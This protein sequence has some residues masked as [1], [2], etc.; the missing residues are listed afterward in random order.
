MFYFQGFNCSCNVLIH[1][2]SNRPPVKADYSNGET[3]DDEEDEDTVYECPGLAP[4]SRV[5]FFCSRAETRGTP[6]N[7]GV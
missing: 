1:F 3:T 6:N 4:V 2:F 5:S 7:L